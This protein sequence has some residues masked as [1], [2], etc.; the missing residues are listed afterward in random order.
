MRCSRL[1]VEKN[2]YLKYSKQSKMNTQK[3]LRI[4]T[5]TKVNLLIPIFLV[6]G[7]VSL[8]NV[9]NQTIM[10]CFIIVFALKILTDSNITWGKWLTLL[11][12]TNVATMT[13]LGFDLNPVYELMFEPLLVLIGPY[14]IVSATFVLFDKLELFKSIKK[15]D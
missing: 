12:A 8:H 6:F 5:K 15:D 13:I 9:Q 4:D 3:T 14:V 11:I 2:K 1:I 7:W 10:I